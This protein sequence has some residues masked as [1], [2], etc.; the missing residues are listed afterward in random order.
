M[1]DH[2]DEHIQEALDEEGRRRAFEDDEKVRRAVEQLR[3]LGF[4]DVANQ[5]QRDAERWKQEH[6]G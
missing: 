2:C 6:Q 3:N 5:H 4:D 1:C